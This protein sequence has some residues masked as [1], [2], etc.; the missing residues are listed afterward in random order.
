M[1]GF[2]P[3]IVIFRVIGGSVAGKSWLACSTG[4]G[5]VALESNLSRTA[6]ALELQ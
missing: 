6:L 5:V 4:L 3:S 2:A 1:L